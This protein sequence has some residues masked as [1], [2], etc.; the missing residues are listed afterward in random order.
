MKT[1]RRNGFTLIELLV[2]ITIIGILISLLLPAV[3]AARESAR[4]VDCKNNLKQL[5]LATQLYVDEN[6]GY[7]PPACV[8]GSPESTF[9]CGVY[10]KVGSQA[11]MDV[12]RGPLWPYLQVSQTLRC[13]DFI[14][15]TLKYAG[16]GY[17][18]GYGI[19]TQYVAGSPIVDPADP[20]KCYRQSAKIN[21]IACTNNTILFADCASI[22]KTTLLYEEKFYLYPRYKIDGVTSN[23]ATF[24]F[25]HNGCKANAAYCDGH[26]D[27]VDPMELDPLGDGLCGWM[28]NEVMDWE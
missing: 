11:F 14:P 18:S 5:A 26:V 15:S 10:Y 17:I 27:A 19:N 21:R 4:C 23:A 16:S 25:L 9:W 12:S 24:H 1:F 6:R 2:V 8:Q 28:P 3:Q 13:P 22:N 7:Y 20:M